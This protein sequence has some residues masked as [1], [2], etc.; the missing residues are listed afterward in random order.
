MNSSLMK[1]LKAVAG[2]LVLLVL[3][4][5]VSRWWGDYRTSG[6]PAGSGT[7]TSTAAPEGE[8]EPES[9]ESD[10]DEAAPETK[11]VLVLTEGLNFRKEPS[12]DS[13]VIRGLAKGEKMTLIKTESGW[14]QVEA[15]DGTRGWISA[16][17]TYSEVQ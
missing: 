4:G 3:I 17:T 2:I 1:V 12:R 16:N 15:E 11:T 9:A 13:D 14:H 6:A 5:T 10:S 7:T 8:G